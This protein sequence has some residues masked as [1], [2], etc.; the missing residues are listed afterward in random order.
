MPTRVMP[1]QELTPRSDGRQPQGTVTATRAACQ[2][3]SRSWGNLTRRAGGMSLP[4]I[5]QIVGSPGFPV[6]HSAKQRLSGEMKGTSPERS[7]VPTAIDDL[8][9]SI[10][11]YVAAA[12]CRGNLPVRF[13]SFG[14][15]A[16]TFHFDARALLFLSLRIVAPREQNA[17]QWFSAAYGR[18]GEHPTDSISCEHGFPTPSGTSG[19]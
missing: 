14:A 6:L 16:S 13:L 18:Y 1:K 3:E 17:D 12:K 2:M 11:N 8:A 15:P 4:G 7:H 9:V 10:V 19:G 5:G